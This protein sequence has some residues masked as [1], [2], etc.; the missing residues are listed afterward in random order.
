MHSLGKSLCRLVRLSPVLLLVSLAGPGCNLL[1]GNEDPAQ[2]DGL[3][4]DGSSSGG[5]DGGGG[6]SAV[7][8]SGHAG[9][10]TGSSTGS[11]GQTG[12]EG[13][14]CDD[15]GAPACV[16]ENQR[17]TLICTSGFWQPSDSCS[18]TENCDT[19]T[20]LCTLVDEDCV[21]LEPGDEYCAPGEE[22][23]A[24]GRD[25]VTTQSIEE[26]GPGLCEEDD[27]GGTSCED[28]CASAECDAVASCENTP[29]GPDCGTCP[30]GYT[31]DASEPAGCTPVLIGLDTSAGSLEPDL[32]DSIT[33][34]A[35][36]VPLSAQTLT[37]T[38]TAAEGVTVTIDGTEVAFG[39]DWTSPTLDLGERSVELV[40]SQAGQPSQTYTLTVTRGAQQAYLKPSN[41]K[42]Y[43]LFGDAVALSGDGTT[44][45]VGARGEE[46]DANGVNGD[47]ANTG[48]SSAGA[49]YVFVRSGSTW[50]QQAYVK[51]SNSA[52]SDSF[53]SALALSDD[54]NTLVVSAPNEDSSAVG[55]GGE[56]DNEAA[57]GAGA[58]YVF[59]RSGSNW[60]QQAYVKASNTQTS[61]GFGD[62]VA[63]SGD[64]NTL[65]VGATGEDSAATGVNQDQ[66]DDAALGSGAVYVFTRTTSIWTQ[67]A[68]I[69]ASNTDAQ[70]AFG[71][72]VALSDDGHLLAVGAPREDS[73][74]ATDETDDG[75]V[76]AGAVYVFGRS[77][78][79]WAQQEYVKTFNVAA[80]QQFGTVALSGEGTVLAVGAPNG[81]FVYVFTHAGSAWAEQDEMTASN[82]EDDSFGRAVAISG[83]G[84]LIAIGANDEASAATG[85]NGDQ[86][87]D[88]APQAGA[89]YLF[90]RVSAG[91]WS[92][93]GYIKASNTEEG[94]AFYPVALSDD[95]DTLVVG[96][97]NESSAA[98]G[99]NQDQSD[100]NAEWSGAAYV[101]R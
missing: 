27:A 89:V 98:Q 72:S 96:A 61:D 83:D 90:G 7:G 48:A 82:A 20:G 95:G 93:Q 64:G 52:D 41:T 40:L 94:D 39:D 19:R 9:S 55:V 5:S 36:R 63:L 54:G 75:A 42:G 18:S 35:L 58:V 46:S 38:P 56:Q 29:T 81:D 78:S 57:S 8:G 6:D 45:A 92:Q 66:A 16:G 2:A 49:V 15:N 99:V 23:R 86:T 17:F 88:T 37:L 65:A 21:D 87:D 34:Y 4:G 47:Q 14:P 22:R 25:R 44:L 43:E 84:A 70:D 69:K 74:N 32:D 24:C 101:F 62:A 85:I 60:T 77:A 71:K 30:L 10:G 79:V 11:G 68:Y 53:G 100:N 51:A 80:G 12:N 59:A 50:T 91:T 13:E 33:A 97:Q 26:C 67:Q 73:G 1:L 3:G 28:A 31:G 76:D